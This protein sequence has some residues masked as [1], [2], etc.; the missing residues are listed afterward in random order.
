[1]IGVNAASTLPD[2]ICCDVDLEDIVAIE[3][4]S[5]FVVDLLAHPEDFGV[6]VEGGFSALPVMVEC[7]DSSRVGAEEFFVYFG[8]QLQW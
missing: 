6:E 5:S 1:V 4:G 3:E 7:V 2:D 8:T